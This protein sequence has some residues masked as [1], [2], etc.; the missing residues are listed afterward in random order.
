MIV[1]LCWLLVPIALG[2]TIS[3]IWPIFVTR[4]FIVILPA[5]VMIVA[6]GLTKVRLA[7]QL[8]LLVV[9]LLI[10]AQGL[11]IYY[12][13][14]H[15]E[16][17]NWRGLV[18]H[19]ADEAHNGDRV[20][21]LSRFGRRPFEYYLDRHAGLSSSLIPAY[22]TMP[23]GSYAPVVGEL[24]IGDTRRSARELAAVQP[25][26]VWVVL[27]WGG[28]R[29]G[30]DDGAPF[31]RVLAHNYVETDHVFFGRYLKLGLYERS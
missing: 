13:Q 10:C 17:E 14:N 15:K 31:Q 23:W 1:L 25:T 19:V 16:G 6:V 30:D 20:L 8:A 5:L 7:A 9:V 22:P 12:A 27:L 11:G 29:T 4:Y 28:F 26:R 3:L 21:F 18:R 2:A 24:Q